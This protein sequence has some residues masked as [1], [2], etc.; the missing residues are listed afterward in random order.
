LHAVLEFDIQ[1][2]GNGFAER[3][4]HRHT[5]VYAG[6]GSQNKDRWSF[7]HDLPMDQHKK[8]RQPSPHA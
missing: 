5:N 7:N 6:T 1:L 8:V 3:F 2:V 4:A